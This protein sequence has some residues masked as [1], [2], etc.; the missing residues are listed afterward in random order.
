MSKHNTSSLTDSEL[1]NPLAGVDFAELEL[2]AIS[3]TNAVHHHFELFGYSHDVCRLDPAV[4]GVVDA[5]LA[6]WAEA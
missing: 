2:F 3:T 6:R 1:Q 5:D 4:R